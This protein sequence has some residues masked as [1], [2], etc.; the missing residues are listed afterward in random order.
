MDKI[1]EEE[2][3]SIRKEDIPEFCN[4]QIKNVYCCRAKQAI[5][6]EG[7]QQM[8]IHDITISDSYFLAQKGY[9]ESYA[10]NIHMENVE[11]EEM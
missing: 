5:K 8:P 2:L 10:E 4:I 11:I 6:I 1:D 7:L 3:A 9:T